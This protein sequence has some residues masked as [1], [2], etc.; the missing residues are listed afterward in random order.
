MLILRWL[1][2]WF[3][4]LRL[5]FVGIGYLLLTIGG[6]VWCV[7]FPLTA[8]TLH[9]A[10]QFPLP[11]FGISCSP[12]FPLDFFLPPDMQSLLVPVCGAFTLFGLFAIYFNVRNLRRLRLSQI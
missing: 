11:Y 2:R 3:P 7:C 10:R 4:A 12:P 6:V 5:L 8:Y 9:V 1:C